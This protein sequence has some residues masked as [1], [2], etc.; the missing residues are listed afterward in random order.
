MS[1]SLIDSG[2]QSSNAIHLKKKFLTCQRCVL[3]SMHGMMCQL[4]YIS[5]REG[6]RNPS[7]KIKNVPT[8]QN[9]RKRKLYRF[10]FK[11]GTP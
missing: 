11:W 6:I 1:K 3:N 8:T 9:C 5:S 4:N 2:G 7:P 10:F